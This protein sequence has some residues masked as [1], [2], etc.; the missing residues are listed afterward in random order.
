MTSPDT[1]SLR[2]R[3]VHFRANR[4][5]TGERAAARISAFVYGNVIVFAAM[6]PLTEE[7][8]TRWHALQVVLG[9]AVST[10]LAHVFAELVGHSSRADERLTRAEIWNELRDSRPIATTALVPSLLMAVASAGWLPGT[11]A[12]IASEIYLLARIAIIGLVMERLRSRRSSM[13]ALLAGLVLASTAAVITF[14][15]VALGH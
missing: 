11:T 5:L 1:R 13:R 6:V 2:D 15:K 9:V 4:T 12:L 8:A 14:L 10:F 7:D 3:I